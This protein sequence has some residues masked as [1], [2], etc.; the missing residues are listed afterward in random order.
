[1]ETTSHR[2]AVIITCFNEGEYV[3]EAVNSV[4]QQ[5]VSNVINEIVIADDGSDAPTRKILKMI[6]QWD[7]RISILYGPGGAGIAAQ[8]NVAIAHTNSEFLAFLDADDVWAKNKLEQQLPVMAHHPDAGMLYSD[9]YTFSNNDFANARRAGVIDI[10]GAENVFLAYFE[11]D[12]PIIPSTILLR[13][14]AYDQIDGFDESIRVFEDS[15]FFLRLAASTRFVLVNEPLLYKRNRKTSIT[16]GRKDL[17]AHH[18]LVALKA[19]TLYP[20][21]YPRVPR[22]L[23]ERARKLG[24]HYFLMNDTEGAVHLLGL[25][26]RLSPLNVRA[27]MTYFPARFFPALSKRL[28]GEQVRKRQL[29]MGVSEESNG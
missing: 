19:A 6:A 16:G 27:W 20:Q 13:R 8:R 29:A 15:D 5:S 12:P 14:S 24:N 25:A 26:V 18:A 28:L 9:F 21:L 22:R 1:M 23:S 4:L 3:E 10:T 2:V 7:E 17:I 11:H